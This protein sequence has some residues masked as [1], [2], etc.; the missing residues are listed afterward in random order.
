MNF[1][2]FPWNNVFP[3]L[4]IL[5]LGAVPSLICPIWW[6]LTCSLKPSSNVSS[7]LEPFLILLFSLLARTKPS[8]LGTLNKHAV[9]QTAC[10]FSLQTRDEQTVAQGPNLVCC[11]FLYSLWI[12][13]GF[14]IFKLLGGKKTKR[15]IIFHATLKNEIQLCIAC[16]YC[17]ATKAELS[18]CDRD[19]R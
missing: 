5:F 4:L 9:L 11:L 12:K 18:C 10:K 19:Y 3:P 8:L 7:S 13:N 6:A 1:G 15:K 17:H 2:Q 14:Y 16:G